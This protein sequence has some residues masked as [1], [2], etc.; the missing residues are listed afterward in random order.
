LEWYISFALP[1][2]FD[3]KVV[4]PEIKECESQGVE[5]QNNLP[6][7]MERRGKNPIAPNP[8]RSIV[9]SILHK[10]RKEKEKNRRRVCFDPNRS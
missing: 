5:G 6:S 10:T 3:H 9:K 4:N 8:R 7:T 2:K 1:P